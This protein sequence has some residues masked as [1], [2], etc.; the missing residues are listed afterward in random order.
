[1]QFKHK[2]ALQQLIV[3]SSSVLARDNDG[4]EVEREGEAAGY[5]EVSAYNYWE[6][7]LLV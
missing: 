4:S 3:P 6:L 7:L 5:H 2:I 1:M